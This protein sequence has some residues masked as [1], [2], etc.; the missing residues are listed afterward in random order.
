MRLRNAEYNLLKNIWAYL[1]SCGRDDLSAELRE[2]L[3]RYEQKRAETRE[4][5]RKRAE[6][7]RKDGY[8]WP[9][10]KRPKTSKYYQK[11]DET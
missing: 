11:E 1:V 4:A 10:I 7:N 2:L 9:S 6:E 5:N 3:D 8:S